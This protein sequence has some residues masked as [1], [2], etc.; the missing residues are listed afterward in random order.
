METDFHTTQMLAHE[1][2]IRRA[3]TLDAPF[4]LKGSYVTRQY[5]ENPTDRI[6]ADLDWNFLG[7]LSNVD[8]ARQTFNAWVTA[9]TETHLADG[10]QFR[11]FKENAFWRMIDYAMADDFPTVNT[12]LKCWLDG[13][14]F[15]FTMDISFNLDVEV[16]PIALIYK[17]LRGDY[18][19]VPNTVPLALQVSWKM[20]QTL[21]RPRFK[22]LFDL[23][24]LLQHPDFNAQTLSD[25][26]QAL[27]NECS[28]D[29][30]DLQ[31]LN[32]LI[33]N[34]LDKLYPNKSID[35]NWN[36]WR[37]EIGRFSY[38]NRLI[39]QDV[40]KDITDDTKLPAG[41]FHFKKQF[42]E[43]LEKAGFH[44][45]HLYNLPKP[46]RKNRKSYQKK[47]PSV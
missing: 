35:E 9:V 32:Y 8:D 6:P 2:F 4:M 23:I 34:D 38:P 47:D 14:E 21:V 30:V 29:K 19:I 25:A 28:V 1:A 13:V 41:L 5:F 42:H 27:V 11:S 39:N 46:T 26:L 37:H 3:A 40:A 33:Y 18:F 45:I 15:G 16:P 22:D 12:D 20:H 31:R 7:I 10:V 43:A 24:H 36:C 44:A 17:P